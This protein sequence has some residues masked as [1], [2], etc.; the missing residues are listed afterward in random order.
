MT[1]WC[2][3][4]GVAGRSAGALA[5]GGDDVRA[6]NGP[7]WVVQHCQRVV[8]VGLAGSLLVDLTAHPFDAQPSTKPGLGTGLVGAVRAA[9]NLAK[10]GPLQAGHQ[11]PAVTRVPPGGACCLLP[12][13]GDRREGLLRRLGV[14]QQAIGVLHEEPAASAQG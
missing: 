5:P 11:V 9:A 8:A 6:D 4:G 14:E 2:A 1:A 3:E 12:R 13:P 10:A 7:G